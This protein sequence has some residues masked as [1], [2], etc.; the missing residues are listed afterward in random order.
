MFSA[1]FLTALVYIAL[2]WC[3]LSSVGLLAM[4]LRDIA[5]GESW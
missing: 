2:I 5:K 1:A 3:A 4:L